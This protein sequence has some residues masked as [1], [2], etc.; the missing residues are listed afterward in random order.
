MKARSNIF[1]YFMRVVFVLPLMPL[2]YFSAI[3]FLSPNFKDVRDFNEDQEDADM[4]S[5]YL[6]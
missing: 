6:S 3:N 2:L 4:S 1:R 5:D